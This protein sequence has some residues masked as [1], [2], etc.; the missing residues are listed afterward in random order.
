[1]IRPILG[2][3]CLALAASPRP[4]HAQELA[5]LPEPLAAFVD[6]ARMACADFEGG[7]LAVE[8]GAVRRVDLDGDLRPDWALNESGFA[9]SSAASLFCGTGGCRTHFLVGGSPGE[10]AVGSFLNRGWDVVTFG[11]DRVVLL[12]VH[13]SACGG[14]NPTPCVNAVVW[15][16]EGGAWRTVQAPPGP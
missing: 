14:I 5:D 15:D 4:S 6:E 11:R 2:L 8:W 1:M 16:G 7:T 10:N 13:G 12:D 3:T 9:C